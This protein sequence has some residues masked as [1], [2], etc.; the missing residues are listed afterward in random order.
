M[1]GFPAS[2]VL[3][4]PWSGSGRTAN[5]A[6]CWRD[7]RVLGREL[8]RLRVRLA[9]GPARSSVRAGGPLTHH[10]QRQCSPTDRSSTDRSSTDRHRI[11]MLAAL[12]SRKRDPGFAVGS[13][14][15]V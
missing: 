9:G 3:G 8:A 7:A 11:S 6:G 1:P 15:W 10:P 13:V 5:L 12:S 2:G 4:L 14:E